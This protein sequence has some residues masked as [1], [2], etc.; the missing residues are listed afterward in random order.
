MRKKAKKAK[1]QKKIQ[2]GRLK[3]SHFSKSPI[4]N[5]FRKNFMDWSLGL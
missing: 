3:K 5:I 1:I 2:N 4:L